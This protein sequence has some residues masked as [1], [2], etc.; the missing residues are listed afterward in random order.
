MDADIGAGAQGIV[1]AG[2]GDG[3]IAAQMMPAFRDA[4]QKGVIVVRSSR[5]GNGIVARNGEANDDKEDLIV[6]DTLN[7]QKAR[8]LLMLALTRSHDTK[9]IQQMFYTY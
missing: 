9:A 6:S 2:V 7:A 8:I 4:R 3:S 5:V 1:Q